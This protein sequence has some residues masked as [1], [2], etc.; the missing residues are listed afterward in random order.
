MQEKLLEYLVSHGFLSAALADE[1]RSAQAETRRP[2]RELIQERSAVTEDQLLEALSF[3]SRIPSVRLYEHA[4]PM[5]VRQLVRAD[6]LRT[7]VLIPFAF[8]PE[9]SGT[10]YVALNDPMNMKGRDMVAIASKCR[11]RPFLAAT[12]DILVA[13]DRYYGTEEMR[14]AAELYTQSSDQDRTVEEQVL[15]EDINSS[16]VVMLVNSL[17]EQAVR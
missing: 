7:Y 11:I 15:Q 9:D 14:E 16:P 2:M 17:V 12:S 3:V 4:I 1:L 6:I 5:D 13:I 8:D 10:L